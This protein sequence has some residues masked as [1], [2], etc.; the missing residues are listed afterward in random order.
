MTVFWLRSFGYE[1]FIL[2]ETLR[3][4]YDQLDASQA[5]YQSFYEY[6]EVNLNIFDWRT[7]TNKNKFENN[8]RSLGRLGKRC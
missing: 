4:I 8:S 2:T 7:C 6:T 1:A 5:W 3:S